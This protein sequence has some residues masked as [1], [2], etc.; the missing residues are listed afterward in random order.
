MFTIQSKAHLKQQ[1]ILVH[2]FWFLNENNYSRIK[3]NFN[4]V[5]SINGINLF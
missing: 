5:D 4:L 1:G 2:I 3:L